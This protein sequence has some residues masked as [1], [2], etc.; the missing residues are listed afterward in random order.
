MSFE[1]IPVDS[2]RDFWNKRPCNIR[3]SDKE[4]GTV[5][6]Y[7]EVQSRKYFVEPHIPGF[8]SFGAW[9]DKKVLEIGCGLG[10]DTI[11]FAKHGAIVTAVD[12]SEESLKL[13]V[14]RAKA[15][16]L[17][18]QITFFHADVEKLSDTVPVEQYDLIYSFGVLH[19]TPHPTRAISELKKYMGH[20]SILKIMV[21]HRNSLKVLGIR[22]RH[23]LWPVDAAIAMNS[24]AQF[25]CP[26]TY[27]YTKKSVRK[28]L[29]GFQVTDM[30]V[31]HIFPYVVEIYK[32]Y[33]YQKVWYFSILPK[34]LFRWLEKRLGWHLC[35]TATLAD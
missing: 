13:A 33:T 11:M 22:L 24:E 17:L 18:H 14:N 20:H 5:E 9:K 25:G 23:P 34:P 7:N 32:R 15:F 27:T 21:Y 6:Y 1:S 16:G 2:V 29:E 12:Y 19:H 26:V 4:V 35:V 10:T 31:D 8:A 28:L 3:H 30:F